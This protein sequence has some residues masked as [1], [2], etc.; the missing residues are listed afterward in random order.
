MKDLPIARRR[1]SEGT[2]CLHFVLISVMPIVC[3]GTAVGV[4]EQFRLWVRGAGMRGVM[5]MRAIV[6]QGDECLVPTGVDPDLWQLELPS[7]LGI[8]HM[9]DAA[10]AE[11]EREEEYSP[12][13]A[14]SEVAQ[15]NQTEQLLEVG[16]LLQ[17]ESI[18]KVEDA[19]VI[20]DSN[21]YGS[22]SPHAEY[23]ITEIDME[24]F[25]EGC[26]V[27]AVPD[28]RQ[29]E[30][31]L[32]AA[33][34]I[35]LEVPYSSPAAELLEQWNVPLDYT[36]VLAAP[37]LSLEEPPYHSLELF[38]FR[39]LHRGSLN[40]E[41]MQDFLRA[42]IQDLPEL[43]KA[44]KRKCTEFAV[45]QHGKSLSL[46][47][48]SYV[49]G[50]IGGV[51]KNTRLFPWVSRLL[52]AWVRGQ[53][54]LHVFS[55]ISLRLNTY[56]APHLDKQNHAAI[57]NLMIACGRWQGG[58]LWVCEQALPKQSS[59]RDMIGRVYNVGVPC[60]LFRSHWLHSTMAW[61]GQRFVL[62]A[63]ANK[64]ITVLNDEDKELLTGLGFHCQY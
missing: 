3:I 26:R 44:R 51:T 18:D 24:E 10:E 37:V 36:C 62:V 42:I 49:Q 46:T 41:M 30:H 58:G 29:S 40:L 31:G 28:E 12:M 7:I 45:E 27:V 11:E 50:G 15:Q 56:M 2:C 20:D 61:K 59:N 32:V 64:G 47:W 43:T 53:K 13:T 17:G 21:T 1:K 23:A 35:T 57:P 16:A 60:V 19:V 6:F 4:S 14:C 63:Y 5:P 52:T 38:A 55:S 34:H 39:M 9:S 8:S 54:P 25:D 48:G 22:A 33:P